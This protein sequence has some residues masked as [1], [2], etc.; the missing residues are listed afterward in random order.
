V[1]NMDSHNG[2]RGIFAVM[3]MVFHNFHYAETNINLQGSAVMTLFFLLSGFS[4]SAV[5]GK[6]AVDGG[7]ASWCSPKWGRF[8]RNRF[9]RVMPAFW[10]VNLLGLATVWTGWGVYPRHRAS[11][12]MFVQFVVGNITGLFTWFLGALGWSFSGPAWTVSTLLFCYTFFPPLLAAVRYG[13]LRSGWALFICFLVQFLVGFGLTIAAGF[14]V[15]TMLPYS[16][17]PLFAMGVVAGLDCATSAKDAELKQYGTTWRMLRCCFRWR[18]RRNTENEAPSITAEGWA[19][20]VDCAAGLFLLLMVYYTVMDSLHSHGIYECDALGPFCYGSVFL[21]LLWGVFPLLDLVVGLTRDEGRSLTARLCN[22]PVSRWLGGIS[23]SLYLVHEVVIYYFCAVY[24]A[25][26]AYSQEYLE[27]EGV[28]VEV[29][30]VQ[31]ALLTLGENTSLGTRPPGWAPLVCMPLALL[32]GWALARCVEAPARALLGAK[33][34]RRVSGGGLEGGKAV[35]P[36]APSAAPDG[37]VVPTGTS[38]GVEEC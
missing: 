27:R 31:K 21:Q 22:H 34:K 30:S 16:R 18:R 38:A 3:V 19:L 28:E 4:L 15:G 9:A 32:L 12:F 14:V 36:L 5:Y 2:L 7:S 35:S 11:V 13:S 37:Q 25:G 26:D 6:P 1:V 10:A 33:K 24:F 23:Y 17:F 29:A 8:Y 20:R